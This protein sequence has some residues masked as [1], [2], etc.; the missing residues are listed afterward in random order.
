MTEANLR[1]RAANVRVHL[2]GL[3]RTFASAA[4][5]REY[6]RAVPFISVPTELA[7]GW[8]DDLYHPDAAAHALAFAPA[9]RAALA[10]FDAE[11]RRWPEEAWAGGVEAFIASPAGQ[12]LAQAAV[13]ALAAFPEAPDAEPG[14]APDTAAR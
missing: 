6:Q 4:E 2:L 14:A 5:Q 7:C 12:A 1:E 11:F 10:G 3:L 8:A 13:A 9:E